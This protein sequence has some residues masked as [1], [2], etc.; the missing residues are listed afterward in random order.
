MKINGYPIV[1]NPSNPNCFHCKKH[2]GWMYEHRAV[3]EKMIGRYLRKDEEV[4][5]KDFNRENNSPEN[6]EVI[7]KIEH[8]KL[9]ADI[10]RK[11]KKLCRVCGGILSSRRREM[12]CRIEIAHAKYPSFDEFRREIETN[13]YCALGR[14]YGVSCR[15]IKNRALKMGI[16]LQRRINKQKEFTAGV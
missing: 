15:A 6:L 3:A 14:K 12:K 4:H 8:R 9:H 7:S 10:I 5:H 11:P 2:K 1:Y 13:S 16:Q